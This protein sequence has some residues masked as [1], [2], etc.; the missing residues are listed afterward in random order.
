MTNHAPCQKKLLLHIMK[1]HISNLTSKKIYSIK[2]VLNHN[3]C[4][5]LF[6]IL[7][8]VIK[9]VL[10]CLVT[11]LKILLLKLHLP[12]IEQLPVE[13]ESSVPPQQAADN[14]ES[15]FGYYAMAEAGDQCTTPGSSSSFPA[16]T[17]VDQCPTNC[18]S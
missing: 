17:A 10:R 16:V 13:V 12:F 7:E 6:A 5:T 4:P 11:I 1:C 9:F 2:I 3:N 14:P 18:N 8:A 15:P